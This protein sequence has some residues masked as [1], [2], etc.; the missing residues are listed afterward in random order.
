L[1]EVAR[2]IA[3]PL[4]KLYNTSLLTGSIPSDWKQSN[5]TAVYKSSGSR[6]DPTN[7]RPISVVPVITKILEKLVASQL[8]TYFEQSQLLSPYQ[9]AYH[10]GRSTKQILLFVVDTINQALDARQVVYCLSGS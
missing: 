7:F 10:G 6:D 3:E 9:G 2:E 4:T 1:Q 5:V 8:H